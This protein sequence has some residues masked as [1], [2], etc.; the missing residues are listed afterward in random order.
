MKGL[1]VKDFYSLGYYKRTIPMLVVLMSVVAVVTKDSAFASTY[2]ILVILIYTPT[3]FQF[4]ESAKW[5]SFSFSLPLGRNKIVAARYLF[6]GA[7]LFAA[8]V[9]S[10]ILNFVLLLIL[11]GLKSGWA[12]EMAATLGVSV[13]MYLVGGSITLPA[14]YKYGPTKGRFFILACTMGLFFLFVALGPHLTGIFDGANEFFG[15]LLL[16][17][18]CVLVVAL[19]VA[20]YFLSCRIMRQKDA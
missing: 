4:D 15:V 16:V 10:V 11:G 14:C 13:I 2:L 5:D 9:A 18:L 17:G 6:L 3:L 8:I 1:F 7:T 12:L 19:Y 20:S